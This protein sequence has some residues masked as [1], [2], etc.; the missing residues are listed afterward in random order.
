MKFKNN[1]GFI[2]VSGLIILIIITLI[3][4]YG[5]A[6]AIMQEKISGG[7]QDSQIAFQ[8]AE[9]ALRIAE[10]NV[11]KSLD[12]NSGFNENCDNG[13]CNP[14]LSTPVWVNILW[15]TDK[16][17]TIQ[18]SE[19]TIKNTIMQPKYIV[20]LLDSVPPSSGESAK[21]VGEK[22]AGLAFRITTVAWGNRSGSKTTLQSIFV[23]R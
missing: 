10:D 13:L 18:L 19:G 21:K 8:N 5:T 2:L 20:E 23:K 17:H 22:G 14:S 11:N 7:F 9:T 1:Q 3:A 16:S 15:E 4:L 6:N 12:I